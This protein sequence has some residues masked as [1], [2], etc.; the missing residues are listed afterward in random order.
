MNY[1]PFQSDW[2]SLKYLAKLLFHSSAERV[3]LK[4]SRSTLSPSLQHLKPIQKRWN[5]RQGGAHNSHYM[6]YCVHRAHNTQCADCLTNPEL[7]A[8]SII[9]LT[10]LIFLALSFFQT[11]YFSLWDNFSS[12]L[13]PF[14]QSKHLLDFSDFPSSLYIYFNSRSDRDISCWCEKWSVNVW[15]R[16]VRNIRYPLNQTLLSSLS[17]Y[18]ESEPLSLSS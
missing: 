14:S 17:I 13:L 18:F 6:R 1:L 2:Q 9:S 15:N 5:T 12:R 7:N 16:M 10:S 3:S 8:F 4:S 11:W